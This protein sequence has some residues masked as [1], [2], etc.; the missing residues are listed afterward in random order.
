M[1]SRMAPDACALWLPAWLP[2]ISLAQLMFDDSGTLHALDAARQY[3]R[4]PQRD[5]PAHAGRLAS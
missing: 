4:D 3:Q 2:P 5:A 1:S